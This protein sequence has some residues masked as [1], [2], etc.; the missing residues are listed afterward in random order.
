MI[1]IEDY[2][3]IW[4]FQTRTLK[5]WEV[6]FS[7]W[8]IDENLYLIL[9]WEIKIEKFTSNE[10]T[11][12]KELAI[13]KKYDFFWEWSLNNNLPKD[14][15]AECLENTILIF[16]N[17]KNWIQTLMK[18]Y[19]NQ[20]LDLLKYI[21]EISNKRLLNSNKQLTDNYEIIKIITNIKKIND[22][23]IFEIIDQIKKISWFDYII[24]LETNAVL[25]N[26]ETLK[27]DTRESWK[28][29]D[30]II[31]KE[32]LNNESNLKE[33]ANLKEK[34]FMQKLNIWNLNLWYMIF[35]KKNDFTYENKKLI[36]SIA[37]NLTW[38]LKQKQI[39][40]EELNKQYMKEKN[41]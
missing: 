32:S 3:N 9:S 10:K 17:W 37:N 13:L 12:K 22:K 26:Y 21:I 38:L 36:I 7:E 8:E 19:P 15:S 23:N 28:L 2:K 25:D 33:I 39:L 20:W 40:K 27:Y 41:L 1:N 24:F 6:V 35:C 5:K 14:V 34:Y 11:E 18:K 4:L 29:K 31:D 16:I 30:I